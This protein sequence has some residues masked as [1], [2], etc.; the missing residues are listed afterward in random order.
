[1]NG[2]SGLYDVFC[3]AFAEAWATGY[4]SLAVLHAVSAAERFDAANHD[5][6]VEATRRQP[7]LMKW[8]YPGCPEAD[9]AEGW[10]GWYG[11]YAGTG[12]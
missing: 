9:E 1:M 4:E 8:P 2:N 3:V 5:R 10:A 12:A 6:F 11:D 7:G